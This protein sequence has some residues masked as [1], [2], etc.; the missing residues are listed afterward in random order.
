[1]GQKFMLTKCSHPHAR[2]GAQTPPANRGFAFAML[3]F[4]LCA[5][6]L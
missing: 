2:I 6:A 4:T 5:L 3:T 1:M